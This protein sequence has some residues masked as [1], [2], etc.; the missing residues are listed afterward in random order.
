MSTC[1]RWCVCAYVCVCVCVSSVCL[2]V[3]SACV[4]VFSLARAR[5]V[6]SSSQ[7]QKG[8]QASRPPIWFGRTLDDLD[9]RRW[10]PILSIV[11]VSLATHTI[12]LS[13]TSWRS[14]SSQTRSSRQRKGSRGRR[15]PLF[16]HFISLLGHHAC[17]STQHKHTIN[18]QNTHDIPLIISTYR[19]PIN[20]PS[21]DND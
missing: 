16:C 8:K 20:T 1:W 21:I 13:L 19:R 5:V 17:N 14:R 18:T 2:C 7:K 12:N 4:C 6:P 15:P 9:D 10:G 3:R 11:V